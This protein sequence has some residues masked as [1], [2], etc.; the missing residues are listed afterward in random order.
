MPIDEHASHLEPG[1]IAAY[2]ATHYRVQAD[3]PFVLHI[4]R[5]SA[6]L[7]VWL[8][9]SG[10][11][12]A[13]YITAWNPLGVALGE[14]D[15]TV[16]QARLIADLDARGLRWLP[17]FGAHADDPAQGEPSLLVLGVDRAAACALGR[18][19]SQNAVVWAGADAVP[20]L[21]LLR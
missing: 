10:V 5:A 20:R 13:L 14:A 21:L 18:A 3:P 19:Q 2:R 6:P 8:D 9:R 7:A 11:R 12:A 15:N 16:R 17:G 1:L 4:D